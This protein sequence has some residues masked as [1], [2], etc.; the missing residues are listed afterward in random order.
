ML[1]LGAILRL[2]DGDEVYET[3]VAEAHVNWGHC[4]PLVTTVRAVGEKAHC[5][6]W[7]GGGTTSWRD[8]SLALLLAVAVTTQG[9]VPG[10]E[11]DTEES[12]AERWR[13]RERNW[14]NQH[15]FYTHEPTVSISY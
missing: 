4:S 1:L 11:A 13:E 15:V 5:F 10:N 14:E 6:T 8:V 12:Q 3:L 9:H 7:W 2:C